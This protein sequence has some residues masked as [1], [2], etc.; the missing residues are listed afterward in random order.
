MQRMLLEVIN[1]EQQLHLLKT[2]Q[3]PTVQS[4]GHVHTDG[5]LTNVQV[6]TLVQACGAAAGHE[7]ENVQ[8][9][10]RHHRDVQLV[11][12]GGYENTAA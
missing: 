3:L 10:R 1:V 8:E 7:I 9:E 2:L 12:W 5:H 6:P 11:F 4:Q